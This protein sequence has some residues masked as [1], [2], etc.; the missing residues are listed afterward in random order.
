MHSPRGAFRRTCLMRACFASLRLYP[1]TLW[2]T[3]LDVSMD[4]WFLLDIGVALCTG[5]QVNAREIAFDKKTIVTTFIRQKLFVYYAPA[6][7]PYVMNFSGAP[8][9]VSTP[10]P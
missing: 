9:W 6:L 2:Q 4:C 1:G 7:V 3:V 10:R 8:I 5:V